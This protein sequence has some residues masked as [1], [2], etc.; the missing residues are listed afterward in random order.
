MN[1]HSGK[2]PIAREGRVLIQVAWESG[3]DVQGFLGFISAYARGRFSAGT[4]EKVAL[5]S[6]E[7]LDNA[8]R[9]SS[10]ARDIS[11]ALLVDEA[12]VSVRVTNATVRPRV[13]MLAEQLRRLESSPEAVYASEFERS[14]VGQGR[15]S[16]LGL[17]RIRHETGMT[18]DLYDN[19]NEITLQARCLR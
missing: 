12:S 5:A 8:M 2:L 3:P 11:Y 7:L 9:Y 17:A 15:R 13:E 10:L 4:A 1:G 16:M 6:S 14:V 18:L 19:G